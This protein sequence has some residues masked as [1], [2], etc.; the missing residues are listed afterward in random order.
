MRASK[1]KKISKTMKNSAPRRETKMDKLAREWVELVLLQ[2][3]KTD[4]CLAS[5]NS[6]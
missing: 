4:G 3:Q 6:L 5:S 1:P 2:I